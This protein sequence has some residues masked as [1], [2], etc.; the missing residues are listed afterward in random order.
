MYR[1]SS[2][3]AGVR[4][5]GSIKEGHGLKPS[6]DEVESVESEE[7]TRSEPRDMRQR[8]FGECSRFS[9]VVRED[10]EAARAAKARYDVG[11]GCHPTRTDDAVGLV[12]ER[13]NGPAPRGSGVVR[14]E[15][16]N[17]LM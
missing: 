6:V 11:L 14:F 17:R 2:S 10:L 13:W 3:P 7:G 15:T 5:L 16:C 4:F 12:T 9:T 1:S 8:I